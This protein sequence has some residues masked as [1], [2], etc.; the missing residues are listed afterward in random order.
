MS[1]R[2]DAANFAF[3]GNY[4]HYPPFAS[5]TSDGI[6]VY[7]FDPETGELTLAHT[8]PDVV[9]PSFLALHPSGRFLYAVNEIPEFE[10]SSSGGVSAFAVDAG[11]GGL[12]FLNEQPTHG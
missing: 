7:R 2:S 8:V 12:T 9:N 10:G 1:A 11:T 6:M 3:V 5:G 4:S